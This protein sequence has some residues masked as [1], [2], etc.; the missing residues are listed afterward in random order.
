MPGGRPRTHDRPTLIK[1]ICADVSNGELVINA[2]AAHK[3]NARDFRRWCEAEEFAPLYARA[4][5]DQAHALAEDTL[6]LADSAIGGKYGN[7]DKVRLQVDTR[8]WFTSKIAPKLYGEKLD[9]TSDG[10][11][12]SSLLVVPAEKAPEV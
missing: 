10:R 2:C 7:T 11:P 4:R 1:A 3:I 6:R 9:L 5:I 12:L 8:K